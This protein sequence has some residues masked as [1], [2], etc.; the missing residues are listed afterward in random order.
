M[1]R[2]FVDTVLQENEIYTDLNID[3]HHIFNVMRMSIGDKIE[4]VDKNKGVFIVKII[5]DTPFKIEVISTI[6]SVESNIKV[7]VYAPILKGDKLDFMLQKSTE[8][9]AEHFYFYDADRSVVKLDEKKKQKR[10]I[11]FEKI[12]TEASEQSK[13]NTIPTIEFLGKLKSIDFSQY[14]NVFI[15][16]EDVRLQENKKFASALNK[17]DNHIAIIFGPEGGFTESEVASHNNFTIVQLG[18]RILRA[19]TAPLYMLSVIDSIYN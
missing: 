14:D 6:Q 10:K 18:K 17:E 16:Y 5:E 7:S 19:E 1:Q 8:L 12:V 15:A 4:V 9:G 2:Y 3:T 13:R 11:R